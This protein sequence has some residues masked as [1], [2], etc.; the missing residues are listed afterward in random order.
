MA[1]DPSIIL[2]GL[3]WQD[4]QGKAQAIQ[5]NQLKLQMDRM[6][7]QQQRQQ[8]QSQ[9]ALKSI[10]SDPSAFDPKTGQLTP[11]T[12]NKVTAVDPSTGIEL[13][14]GEVDAAQKRA[15]T[16][17]LNS[18]VM[19][20][21]LKTLATEGGSAVNA[22]D[23]ALASGKD[24]VAARA[25]AQSVW[26]K[27]YEGFSSGQ[28]GP[29]LM[30]NV[31]RK[32]DPQEFRAKALTLEQHLAQQEKEKHDRI[33]EEKLGMEVRRDARADRHEAFE[34]GKGTVYTDT[35]GTPYI[36]SPTGVTTG[37]G[38]AAGKPY[39]PK[40][41]PTKPGTDSARSPNVMVMQQYKKDFIAQNG[42]PPNAEELAGE[43]MKIGAQTG[44]A[45]AFAYGAQGNQLRSANVAINHLDTL[46]QL[47]GALQ[48]GDMRHFNRLK[49]NFNSEFGSP[50][51]TSFDAAKSIVSDEVVKSVIG[52]AGALGDREAAQKSLDR[53]D[54]WKQL[55][56]VIHDYRMLLGGQVKGLETQFENSTGEKDFGK[57][58]LPETRKAINWVPK[59]LPAAKGVAE[60][61]KARDDNGQIVAV[62]KAGQWVAP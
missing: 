34:E 1:T 33:E 8:I 29:E 54:S 59:D 56:G 16:A 50:I 57:F 32:F 43:A 7:I 6:A 44:A 10:L 28:M 55:Q 37:V 40:G 48:N 19:T 4:A 22:Y 20:A 45:K 21:N 18:E 14:K 11:E 15:Q 60:G 46:E 26:D 39:E 27:S 38:A 61:T 42:R 3:S 31:P 52:G 53:A 17:H 41:A 36:I 23:D 30:A 5:G 62:L 13:R 58:L 12:L 9:N 24:D 47:A 35:D 25:I 51:P 2:N 49:Q